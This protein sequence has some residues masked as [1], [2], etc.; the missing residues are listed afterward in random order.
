MSYAKNS[1]LPLLPLFLLIFIFYLNFVS[2]IILAPLLPIVETEL[3]LGHGQAGS[4]FFFVASGYAV[5]LLGAGL[6]SF[7]LTHRLTI[8]FAGMMGGAALIL[9]SLSNSIGGIR[10]GLVIIGMFAGFY[11]PSGIATLTEIISRENW[12]RGMALHELAPNVAFITTPLLSE[13]L[14]KF[15][16]WRGALKAIGIWAILMPVLFLI[17]GRG[18]RKRGDLPRVALMRE[19]LA[20]PSCWIMGLYFTLAIGA[21]YGLYTLMPLFMVAELGMDRVWANS[22]MGFSR[23]FG[24]AVLF[25]SGFFIER[26][27]PR[28]AMIFY[29]S[30][31]GALTLLLGFAHGPVV[32]PTLVFL[33]AASVVCLFPVGFTILSLHFPDPVRGVAVSLVILIGFLM[34]GGVV[35]SALGYWAETFSFSSGFALLGTVF[36]AL[37]PAF[38]KG[39]VRLKISG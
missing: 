12:G 17:F 5:G 2:R 11:L 23:I 7:L 6:V 14:L 29:L 37:L 33:Q 39:G 21:S 27:G 3:G 18:S 15:F 31:T 25:F 8:T 34:G 32:V 22:L 9:I 38:L 20:G 24:V 19:I 30:L 1:S 26:M 35:P 36:L 10:A 28:R 13:F 4:L 16:S